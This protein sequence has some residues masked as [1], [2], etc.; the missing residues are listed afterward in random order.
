MQNRSNRPLR[1]LLCA[2]LILGMALSCA[3][4]AEITLYA[5]NSSSGVSVRIGNTSFSSGEDASSWS[6]GKGWKN[7]TGKYLAMVDFD[8]S[9]T[10]LSADG[11]VLTLAVAGVNR[12]KALK[13]DCSYNIVGTGIVLIDSIDLEEGNTISLQPDSSL[14]KEGSAAVFLKQKDGSYLLINGSVP[15]IL[16]EVYSLD[17]VKLTVPK[18][19]T[20]KL[21]C[22]TVVAETWMPEDS[23]EPVTE[24]I[25]F[26]ASLAETASPSHENGEIIV[27][28][29]PADLTLGASASLTIE[30]GASVVMEE[31]WLQSGLSKQK[32]AAGLTVQGKLTVKG[33]VTGGCLTVKDNGS[34]SGSGTLRS[35]E[36]TL[37]P[38]GTLSDTLLLDDGSLT[39]TGSSR[40]LSAKIKDSVIYLRG[41]HITL[42]ELNVSGASM[43]ANSTENSS[44]NANCIHNITFGSGGSLAVL[45]CSDYSYDS[46]NG[47]AMKDCCLRI[48]GKITGGVVSVLAGC[49]EYSGTQTDVLPTV[50]EMYASRILVFE[51]GVDSTEHPLFMTQKEATERGNAAQIPV[52]M[53]TVTDSL[54]SE[55]I[56]A[57]EWEA[58]SPENLS[59]LD[60]EDDQYFTCASFL[61][62]YGLDRSSF[63]FVPAVEVISAG[64]DRRIYYF[65]DDEIFSTENVIMIRVIDCNSRGDQG[66]SA[67]SH[68]ETIFTGS[69]VLGDTGSGSV[70]AGKGKVVYTQEGSPSPTDPTESTEAE[71]STTDESTTD[72][73]GTTDDNNETETRT[74]DD[75]NETETRT[76]ADNNETETRTT[77][78]NNS[79]ESNT[80]GSSRES[81]S[82]E[83]GTETDEDLT[84]VVT[85]DGNG[86]YTLSVYRR[87]IRLSSLDG[88]SV[89]VKVRDPKGVSENDVC[90]AVFESDGRSSWI[91]ADYNS[92]T[93][94]LVFDADRIGTF[95]IARVSVREMTFPAAS[96]D[97]PV[98][99]EMSV[100]IG[101]EDISDLTGPVKAKAVLAPGETGGT[102][103]YAVFVDENEELAIFPMLFDESD[104]T[105]LF[106]ADVT[107]SFVIVR[108]EGVF[109]ADSVLYDACRDSDEVRILITVLRL[110]SFWS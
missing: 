92:G 81:T 82:D 22:L 62:A 15:G 109:G 102:G 46:I 107:G 76:T 79:T 11:D 99:R 31:V 78:G 87:G 40:T 19:S 91:P 8:G 14:Y 52:M 75:N 55:E 66:G 29:S 47:G 56:S 5:A 26:D 2:V 61:E 25:G 77:D 20:L 83:H 33:Q 48:S 71:S 108:P 105:C 67:I 43:V 96:P 100:R 63:L 64:F 12:I 38:A 49:V 68:T 9:E 44:Y 21:G 60:R 4:A 24:I 32:Y 65:N 28:G 41:N 98:Y 95:G 7:L 10:V 37:D 23:P 73:S 34:L 42:S 1:I 97:V 16:D 90:Y 54:V 101:N 93:G 59:P 50:S 72:E 89:T 18:N 35:S 30:S 36:V 51:D 85:D 17:N 86:R 58:S 106:E 110:Y 39:V 104:G 84:A 3:A 6:D 80:N 94:E 13:G 69:G 74:T 103:L 45:A 27:T 53:L 70:T 88:R 57:R